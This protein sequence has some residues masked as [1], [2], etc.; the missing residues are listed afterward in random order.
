MTICVMSTP[1][2]CTMSDPGTKGPPPQFPPIETEPPLL[3]RPT[4]LKLIPTRT[5]PQDTHFM[6]LP[7]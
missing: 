5:P 1:M 2:M 7:Q 6:P 4:V 3:V